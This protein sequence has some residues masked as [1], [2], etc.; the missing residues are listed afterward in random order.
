[1]FEGE[2][3]ALDIAARQHGVLTKQQALDEQMTERQIN[4][5]VRTERWLTIHPGVYRIV[6][7]PMS[8]RQRAMAACL[9]LGDDACVSHDTA[10]RVL[11]LDGISRKTRLHVSV[12]IDAVTARVGPRPF[13]LHR[14]TPFDAVDRTIVDDLPCTSPVR[15]L[16]D[17]AGVVSEETLEIAFE[18]ARRLGLL[19]VDRMAA[20]FVQIGGRGRK[21]SAKVRRLLEHQQVG[22]RPLESPLEVKMWRLLR[23]SGMTM[24]ARQIRIGTYRVDFLWRP[25]SL[26]V[27]CD[28]FEAHA[29]RLR[30]KRDRRRVADLE[31]LGYRLVHVT[32]DDVTKRPDETLRRVELALAE[33][34][35]S[36]GRH[37]V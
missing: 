33:R 25:V 12:P 31:L 16:I 5:R 17:L 35:L 36:L 22:A 21:G 18:S 19:S 34:T 30:W 27:E 13:T 1:M 20:R 8:P 26:I 24:P 10:A 37:I 6:G 4:H 29:G 15:T 23:R 28:G 7:A 3:R 14:V 9:W 32:W 2:Q 11:R